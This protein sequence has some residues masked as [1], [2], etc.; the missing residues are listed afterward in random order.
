MQK[1]ISTKAIVQAMQPEHPVYCIYEPAI[2][3]AGSWFLE[4]F[5]GK[6]LFAV[7]TN[8]WFVDAVAAAGLNHFDVAS[9]A[10]IDLVHSKLPA[11]RM[12][13]MHPVKSSQN[14]SR[15]YFDYGVR[16][17]ALDSEMELEKILK[18][19]NHA[20][21]LALFVRLSVSN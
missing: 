8:P 16:D 5:P 21:D 2:K 9:L 12:S 17:F 20:K 11:A 3:A 10:E 14:I 15:A 18:A 1:F 13:Y 4:N 7:K 19:T 6:T